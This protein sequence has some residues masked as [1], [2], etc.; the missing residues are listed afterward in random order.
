MHWENMPSEL[1]LTLFGTDIHL[2]NGQELKD[3]DHKIEFPGEYS[4][5]KLP[6]LQTPQSFCYVSFYPR[7]WEEVLGFPDP[8]KAWDEEETVGA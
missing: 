7:L 6:P 8:D 1:W 5:H 2:H 3:Y 4:V